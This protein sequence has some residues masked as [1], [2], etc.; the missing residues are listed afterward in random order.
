MTAACLEWDEFGTFTLA[1][2]WSMFLTYS[3]HPTEKQSQ[4]GEVD[5]SSPQWEREA[6]VKL[7]SKPKA[8][9]RAAVSVSGQPGVAGRQFGEGMGCDLQ[10]SVICVLLSAPTNLGY[11]NDR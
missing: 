10:G 8:E 11:L 5:Q 6:Q 7:Q 1:L 3:W 2:S 9:E 4:D